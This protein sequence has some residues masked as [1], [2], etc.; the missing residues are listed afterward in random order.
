[1]SVSKDATKATAAKLRKMIA[2]CEATLTTLRL[3]LDQ[4]EA[5]I[6]GKIIPLSGLD[7][8]WKVALP[9]ARNRSSKHLCRKAMNLIPKG[10]RPAIEEMI[11]ALKIWNRC[12]EWKKDGNQFVPALDR[13]IRERRWEDLPEVAEA[14]SRY[15]NVPVYLPKSDPADAVNDPAEVAKLLSLKPARMNS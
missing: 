15:R 1:M 5:K 3:K 7:A 6:T 11:S 9:I 8:L 12:Q 2:D 13:W 4:A 14:G 10:E